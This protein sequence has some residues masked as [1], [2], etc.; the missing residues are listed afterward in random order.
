MPVTY[1][2]ASVF[3]RVLGGEDTVGKKREWEEYTDNKR[4]I[5]RESEL[6][7]EWVKVCLWKK[8][9]GGEAETWEDK[10]NLQRMVSDE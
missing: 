2:T 5:N 9:R 7:S 6:E 4:A 1:S 8:K 10:G 3:W